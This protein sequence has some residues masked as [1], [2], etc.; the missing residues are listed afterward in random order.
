VDAGSLNNA[1]KGPKKWRVNM[2]TGK[3]RY[4]SLTGENSHEVMIPAGQ[5]SFSI[6]TTGLSAGKYDVWV[7]QDL[8][9][10][11]NTF[12]NL[13][14][15]AGYPWPRFFYYSGNDK[16]FIDWSAK[17]P[18]E[19]FGWYPGEN[20]SI[21]LSNANIR[22]F[23]LHTENC[24]I[25]VSTGDAIRRFYLSGN[26]ENISIDKC[27]K[28][29]FLRFSPLCSQTETKLYQLPVYGP[30]EKATSIQV[31]VSPIG[32]AFDCTSLLQFPDLSELGLTGNL[33]HL[34]VLAELKH[35][36][37][38]WLWFVPNLSNMPNIATWKNLKAFVALNVE[39]T[40][41][42]A[43]RAE[44]KELL[45]MKG[46]EDNS[47]VSQL[48]KAIWFTTEYGIPF[49]DWEEKNAKVA[50]KAYKAC[51]KEIKKSKT[52]DEVQ[53]AIVAFVEVINRLPDIETVEREDAY[54]AVCQLVESSVLGISQE[55]GSRWFDEIR[56]F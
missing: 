30:F 55:T 29:P 31:E 48:R 2:V 53:K 54:A 28:V 20:A 45:R 27:T 22:T 42:K 24:K 23:S 8:P 44:L 4:Y 51:L 6:G 26:L 41:G 34:E 12:D 1:G 35:L 13:T 7:D 37:K 39:E 38:I 17:R 36:E 18:I 25:A 43:L 3:P 47:T 46:L 11:W 21:D 32:Q 16:G 40:A 14:V 52:E 49:S 19:E 56:D 5:G 33:A 15:P 50:T 10:F 9:I